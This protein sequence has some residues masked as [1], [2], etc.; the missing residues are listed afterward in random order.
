MHTKTTYIYHC[1]M[2]YGVCL[3]SLMCKYL[4]YKVDIVIGAGTVYVLCK[5]VHI[6]RYLLILLTLF[7]ILLSLLICHQ[8]FTNINVFD[9]F[10]GI[11]IAVFVIVLMYLVYRFSSV[12][13][14]TLMVCLCWI[15]KN[16]T[17]CYSTFRKQEAKYR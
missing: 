5:T 4:N 2:V 1:C 15:I 11:I 7:P 9:W 6:Q 14:F 17:S 10:F 13:Q 12:H 3:W 16:Q 8:T